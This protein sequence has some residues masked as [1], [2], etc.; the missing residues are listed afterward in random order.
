MA[1][2]FLPTMKVVPFIPDSAPFNPEQRAWLNGFLAG[3]L[4][5][6]SGNAPISAQPVATEPLLIL[7]GS[8]SGNAEGFAK[9]IG[10][11]APTKGFAPRVHELDHATKL[12]LTKESRLLVVTSTWGEGEMPDNAKAFWDLISQE[13]APQLPQLQYSVLALGD[14]NYPDFCQAGKNIDAQLEKLGAQRIHPC[15]ECDVDFESNAKQWLESSWSAL[16]G[17]TAS[18]S[19]P[20]SLVL[21]SEPATDG[22]YSRKNPFIAKL[23]NNKNLNAPGS[24]KDVRHIE[25]DLTG[26]ELSYEVGDALGVFP[27][28]D[29]SLVES[30]LKTQGWNGAEEITIPDQGK[31][32]LKESLLKSFEI[33]KLNRDF[34]SALL[35][36]VPSAAFQS[37]I[38]PDQ[39]KELDEFCW[40][41]DLL[42]LLTEYPSAKFA[43]QEFVDLLRKLNVRLYSIAS[44][45]K[46]HPN[47]VHLTV[48]AVRFESH[49]RKRGGV[50]S[51]FLADR[52]ER[53]NEIPVFIQVSHGFRPPTNPDTAM[54]MVGPGTGIAPFRAFLEE[55]KA[56]GAKGKNW[57]FFG[58][59]HAKSD[60]LYQQELEDYFREGLLTQLDTAFSRDQTEK[61]YV[62]TRMKEKAKQLWEWLESGAHFYVCGDAS[63]MA[64]DVDQTLHEVIIEEGKK[65]ADEAKEYV[66]KLKSDK[67]YQRDVY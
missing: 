58:D 38:A 1:S 60:F 42:D 9:K 17:T 11:E 14:K 19:S 27:Q 63:R 52:V 21:S 35:T 51:T 16:G 22:S 32:S 28:N 33:T 18:T 57:L 67:R 47:Q 56:I 44:S 3:W 49:G 46:A 48:G 26:S 65:S 10:K 59:Q 64:K 61:I 7:F 20:Q 12:D 54:I 41:R 6:A 30:I 4:N 36:K 15:V 53:G 62:Q 43:P 8:Q 5:E 45:I 25:I 23:L 31:L 24:S 66:K 50:C 13:S 40:G 2:A 55:R 29:P 39:K 37:R 34:L